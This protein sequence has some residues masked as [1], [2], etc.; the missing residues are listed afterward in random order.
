MAKPNKPTAPAVETQPTAPAVETYVLGKQPNIANNKDTKNGK[1]GTA[2]TW[3]L[4]AAHM[5]AN[6]GSIT[7]PALQAICTDNGDKQ[8]AR[9]ARK[10]KWLVP[11]PVAQA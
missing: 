3:A 6:S 4:I 7:L 9:Y 5:A 8:F 1:G 11:A 10:N 2:G